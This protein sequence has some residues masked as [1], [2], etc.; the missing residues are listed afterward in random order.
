MTTELVIKIA[1]D[2]KA[3]DPATNAFAD[4]GQIKGYYRGKSSEGWCYQIGYGFKY[5]NKGHKVT[6]AVKQALEAN[7]LTFQ[8]EPSKYSEEK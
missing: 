7:G 3:I 2:V 1:N 5:N 8:A 6:M 4:G